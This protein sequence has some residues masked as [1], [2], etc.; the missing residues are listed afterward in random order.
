MTEQHANAVYDALVRYVYAD[1]R[2][3]SDFVISHTEGGC[4]EFRFQGGLGW[5]GKYW[6]ER[7]RVT[8]YSEDFTP[9]RQARIEE[10]NRAL[11]ALDDT[12]HVAI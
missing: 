2:Q 8:C 3:R 4:R 12:D 11:A 1:E 10:C 7:N 5:G 9:S 6:S